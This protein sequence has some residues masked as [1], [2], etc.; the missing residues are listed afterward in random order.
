MSNK[1]QGYRLE[2]VSTDGERIPEIIRL[3]SI[4]KTL[5]RAYSFRVTRLV[6]VEDEGANTGEECNETT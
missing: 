5:L 3:R 2:I 1:R 4:V 6:P